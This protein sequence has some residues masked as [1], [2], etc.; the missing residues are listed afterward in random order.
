VCAP[1]EIFFC[2]FIGVK[3]FFLFGI[4]CIKVFFLPECNLMKMIRK[5]EEQCDNLYSL[6][7]GFSILEILLELKV[8]K[9]RQ[10]E[11]ED[12]NDLSLAVFFAN[13]LVINCWLKTDYLFAYCVHS[14]ILLFMH[15]YLSVADCWIRISCSHQRMRTP[16]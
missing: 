15:S 10:K 12:N 2:N 16:S 5:R 11:E 9:L 8:K 7:L 1:C 14:C 6:L 3:K 13:L 4:T